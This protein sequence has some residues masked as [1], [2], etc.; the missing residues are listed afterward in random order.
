MFKPARLCQSYS[1]GTVVLGGTAWASCNSGSEHR[2]GVAG[3][4]ITIGENGTMEMDGASGFY[5]DC[6][7]LADVLRSPNRHHRYRHGIFNRPSK[8]ARSAFIMG[9][10]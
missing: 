3:S 6:L 7:A 4:E 1:G 9:C 5:D 2:Y 8:F 10:I